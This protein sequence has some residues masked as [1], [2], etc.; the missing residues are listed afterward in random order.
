MKTRIAVYLHRLALSGAAS[1]VVFSA[2]IGGAATPS[3]GSDE[4]FQRL[5]RDGDGALAASELSS[6]HKRLFE[7]LL[8]KA[9]I[10]G[11]KSLSREEFLAALVPSRPEKQIESKQPD[12]YPQANAVR[13]VLLMMDTRKDSWIEADE[14]PKDM[15]AVYEAMIERLDMNKNGSMDRYEL[16]RGARELGQIAGRYVARERIDVAKEL[17]KFDKSQGEL[18]QRFDKPPGPILGNL[19][20]P[21]QARKVFK[22]FDVNSD[23]KLVLDELPPPV[24]PQFE[25]LMRY[26]DRDRNGGLSEREFLTAAERVSR[27]MSGQRPKAP[28]AK[29]K[30]GRDGRR[31]GKTGSNDAAV[32]G[33]M[34]AESMPAEDS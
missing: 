5:D 10:N 13:Y 15:Q 32:D 30:P 31:R 19:G 1:V 28:N 3:T 25:R 29:P 11:N 18:A 17:K 9:D 4:L 7:R 26:A 34:S 8:R 22:Q 12:G 23:K 2:A 24:Q 27:V 6:D 21:A 16:A 20:D 33:E 14:V